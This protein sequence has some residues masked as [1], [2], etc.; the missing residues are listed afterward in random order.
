MILAGDIGG[1][2]TRL[3][4]FDGELK[5]LDE[6]TF[7]NANR[8]GLESAVAEFVAGLPAGSTIEAACIGVA[9]PVTG[10]QVKLTNLNWVVDEQSLARKLGTERVALVNDL[11]VHAEGIEFLKPENVI[12][13]NTGEAD[14][15]GNRAVIAAGTGL[16]EAG[17]VWDERAGHHQ[18]VACEGGH[19]DF[20]PQSEREWELLG[21]LKRRNKPTSW[22]AVL[23]G[24]GLRHLYD[25]LVGEE[26]MGASAALAE[27]DPTPEVISAAAAKRSNRACIEAMGM[28]IAFYG[29]EAGNLAL[30]YLATGGIYIGGG[31]APLV[32]DQ[33][34]GARRSSSVLATRDR[35]IS[36]SCSS[37]CR[38]ASSTRRSMPCMGRP[39][40]RDA[41][42]QIAEFMVDAGDFTGRGKW[43]RW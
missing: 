10:G 42:S 3:A 9:G 8:P 16:G 17:L 1:T 19:C 18:A 7:E 5:L 14:P 38:S 20:A 30:K 21:F 12:S 27:K 33:I 6:Q 25:F 32:A 26:Q 40:T 2:N 28:F 22:E 41:C 13:L 24:P 4:L 36:R 31:I 39:I 29:A 35:R 34:A 37:A 11:R 23:S 15:K 43:P